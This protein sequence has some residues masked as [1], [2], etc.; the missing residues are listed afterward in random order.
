MIELNIYAVCIIKYADYNFEITENNLHKYV[1]VG[2]SN[3]HNCLCEEFSLKKKFLYLI[4]LHY[5]HY[6]PTVSEFKIVAS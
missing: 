4:D 6:Q 1:Y 5:V 2:G 3:R